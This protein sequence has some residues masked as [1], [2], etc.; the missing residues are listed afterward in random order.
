MNRKIARAVLKKNVHSGKS[1][2]YIVMDLRPDLQCLSIRSWKAGNGGRL[3]RT[4]LAFDCV[5]LNTCSIL[6]SDFDITVKML[7]FESELQHW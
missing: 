6:R 1:V 7:A 3:C 2:L 5:L 4:A